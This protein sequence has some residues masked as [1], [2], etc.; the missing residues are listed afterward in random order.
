MKPTLTCTT[1]N[2]VVT[3]STYRNYTHVVVLLKANGTAEGLSWS[4]DM[5]NAQKQQAY[6]QNT[7]T[8]HP[9]ADVHPRVA[10]LPVDNF[11][12]CPQCGRKHEGP[13]G[14]ECECGKKIPEWAHTRFDP[15]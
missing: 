13:L 7:L 14:N 2:G 6:W 9:L 11:W 3:R 12:L 15:K 4:G 8:L 10:I 1:P 5:R